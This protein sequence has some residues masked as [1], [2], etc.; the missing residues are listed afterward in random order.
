MIVNTPQDAAT[1]RVTELILSSDDMMWGQECAQV[2][3]AAITEAEAAGLDQYAYAARMRLANNCS[4]I[5]DDETLLTTFSI[6]VA[7][8][9]ED[10]ARFPRNP[11]EMSLPGLEY[12]YADLM[13]IYKWMPGVLS[14]NPEF[15]KDDVDGAIADMTADYNREG[16][17]GKAIT[18]VNLSWAINKGANDEVAHWLEV[19]A[20]TPTDDYGNCEA[21]SRRL[22]INAA[23]Q[24]GDSKRALT[25]LN[26]LIHGDFDC[27]EEPQASY[28]RCLGILA[29]AGKHAE[30]N[31]AIDAILNDTYK[32]FDDPV[33][34][35]DVAVFLVTTGD[36]PRALAL[37]KRVLH[38]IEDNPLDQE[39]HERQLA[40]LAVVASA[41]AALAEKALP[42]ADK[43]SLARYLGQEKP[44]TLASAGDMAR[45]AA[46]DLA[47]A[48]DL[49]N[50]TDQ[51][52]QRITE[53]L[54]TVAHSRAAISLI[55]PPDAGLAFAESPHTEIFRRDDAARVHPD[56]LEGAIAAA[57]S[58]AELGRPSD[59][60]MI[61]SEWLPR[62]ENAMS[63]AALLFA[64]AVSS[65]ALGEEVAL[66]LVDSCASSL[67]DAN[68]SQLGELLR[69]L[70]TGAL[71]RGMSDVGTEQVEA[72]LSRWSIRGWATDVC[73]VGL[74]LLVVACGNFSDTSHAS[75]WL[76]LLDAAAVEAGADPQGTRGPAD[77][78]NDPL[79]GGIVQR[80]RLVLILPAGQGAPSEPAELTEAGRRHLVAAVAS[81]GWRILSELA[82]RSGDAEQSYTAAIEHVSLAQAWAGAQMRAE[83]AL[84]LIQV[85]GDQG[86]G[87]EVLALSDHLADM[88]KLL[89]PQAALTVHS[90]RSAVLA[91]MGAVRAADAA[92]SDAFDVLA[93]QSDRASEWEGRLLLQRARLNDAKSK[94]TAALADYL[95]AARTCEASGQHQ[96]AMEA[97]LGAARASLRQGSSVQA[98][99]LA[100]LVITAIDALGRNHASLAE[101]RIIL[102]DAAERSLN[103]VDISRALY[104]EALASLGDLD[105][106]TATNYRLHVH[107]ALAKS[108]W[109]AG[110]DIEAEQVATSGLEIAIAGARPE[111]EV[112]YRLLLGRLAL[113]QNRL[114][115]AAAQGETLLEERYGESGQNEGSRL[116]RR[117]EAMAPAPT[118]PDTN[119]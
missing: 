98:G 22:L 111:T 101:A 86:R 73:A 113:S 43:P 10:P 92:T 55:L 8:H 41:N 16:I 37:V 50:G 44:H 32:V 118:Q 49:R 36:A 59:A 109:S 7:Q 72:A 13:W 75:D 62:A 117:A 28:A 94:H 105:P 12:P 23:I 26:E 104:L 57:L 119:K 54:A 79:W 63:A 115:D 14:G 90:V 11:A 15:S 42:E 110:L 77:L 35:S 46:L 69:E 100:E 80:A 65:E 64:G 102:A 85:C 45:R 1:A 4:Q 83:A 70:G 112:P 40:A 93:L 3:G 58:Y 96:L 24:L 84:H 48:F 67:A 52:T 99:Q 106:R 116:Q 47:A 2:L 108:L 74:A 91:E 97:A 6:I 78:L 31:I 53:I 29:D 20:A 68:Q 34:L 27:V 76:E 33:A 87:S 39:T 17:P 25:I 60:L 38:C 81:H 114:A 103:D 21:C 30:L 107:E 88:T 19:V 89:E 66:E 5:D 71:R 51:H 56:S 18:Q 82:G 95:S 61:M 9:G